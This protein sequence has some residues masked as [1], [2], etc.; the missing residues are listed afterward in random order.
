MLKRRRRKPMLECHRVIEV[1]D[2]RSP[3]RRLLEDGADKDGRVFVNYHEQWRTLMKAIKIGYLRDSDNGL[4][5]AGRAFL[6]SSA[7]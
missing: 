3:M 6:A 7:K 5:D 4:T 2:K 1:G